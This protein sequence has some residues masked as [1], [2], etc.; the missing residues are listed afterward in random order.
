M[1]GVDHA[2]RGG[3]ARLPRP[4]PAR[5]APATA[6]ASSGTAAPGPWPAP[7][8]GPPGP[9]TPAAAAAAP[10]SQRRR[11][12]SSAAACVP[13]AGGGQG[14][15][16]T[17]LLDHCDQVGGVDRGG[18]AHPRGLGGEVD[19]RGDP[20]EPVEL[21]LDP[22][23]ARGAGHPADRQLGGAH[24]AGTRR[25]TLSAGDRAHLHAAPRPM[26]ARS[27]RSAR[28]RAGSRRPRPGR[29][30][31][32]GGQ[33]RVA[34][35][36][37]ADRPPGTSRRVT[38]QTPARLFSSAATAR[39][40]CSHVIPVTWYVTDAM[41]NSCPCLL[42]G[43]LAAVSG[44]V[45]RTAPGGRSPRMPRGP[46]RPPRHR[47]RRPPGR[48]SDPDGLPAGRARPTAA[49]AV[50]AD[51]WVR[52]SMQYLSSS[53]IRCRPRTWPSIRRSRTQVVL[54]AGGVSVH[55]GLRS[56]RHAHKVIP[57]QGIKSRPA[58]PPLV[59]VR[60]S[61]RHL[62]QPPASRLLIASPQYPLGV[63][64]LVPARQAGR[65]CPAGAP[66]GTLGPLRCGRNGA[67]GGPGSAARPRRPACP[68]AGEIPERE[69][70]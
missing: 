7:P 11:R 4:P 29:P 1:P 67:A 64:T 27:S 5:P 56:I 33:R 54:L 43:R 46:S 42:S 14:R 52:M 8:P 35:T 37:T 9:A 50:T 12:S 61:A 36:V 18:E 49:P 26:R 60:T 44:P 16:V 65:P 25:R 45:V 31:P 68:G 58:R 70:L 13:S 21:P 41:A 17:G 38:S 57:P 53:T 59:A 10:P 20:V 6:T 15:G 19:R 66:R 34:A 32:P 47:P 63:V 3:T 62:A 2:R 51:T 28:R 24:L 39:E 48:R 55:S 23:R 40:Q 22:G 30:R 69:A